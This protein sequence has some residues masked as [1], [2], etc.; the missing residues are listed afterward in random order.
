MRR[1]ASAVTIALLVGAAACGTRPPAV[2]VGTAAP[3]I[4]FALAE[5]GE[6]RTEK[7]SGD[8]VVLAFFTVWCPSS[9][10]TLRALED[11]RARNK[12]VRGLT[13][14]A[15]DEG[16]SP[17]DV[18]AL[19]AKLG[20]RVRLGF[21]KGGVVANQMGLVTVPSVIVIDRAGRIRHVH[22]GYHGDGDRLAIDREIA[23]LV[24]PES[25]D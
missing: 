24:A 11:I 9:S 14:I 21:D 2:A 7:T 16:D 6:H 25:A 5:G 8:V 22:A 4:S 18:A 13:I 12:D 20:I 1:I 3:S 17:A 15:V 19:A 23:A 10:A